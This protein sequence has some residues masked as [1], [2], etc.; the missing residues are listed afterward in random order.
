MFGWL[1]R[2]APPEPPAPPHPDRLVCDALR[3]RFVVTMHDGGTFEGLLIDA[4]DR[5]LVL[6]QASSVSPQGTRIGVDGA[7]YLERREIAYLQRP[8]GLPA[9]SEA[10]D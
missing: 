5:V 9:P 6:A 4:D 8:D 2:S 10:G 1:R 3:S 7:L